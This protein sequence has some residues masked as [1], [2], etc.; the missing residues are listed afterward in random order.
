M[1]MQEAD[2]VVVLQLPN[3]DAH[4]IRASK[5]HVS[6][7][8]HTCDGICV[9]S[10]LRDMVVG[11]NVPDVYSFVTATHYH[12]AVASLLGGV[13]CGVF[14]ISKELKTENFSPYEEILLL[15]IILL[16]LVAFVG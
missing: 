10:E 11:S 9:P 2:I 5:Q 12:I 7:D 13:H 16:I 14:R 4:V 3:P 1:P 6:I 8:C 15:F